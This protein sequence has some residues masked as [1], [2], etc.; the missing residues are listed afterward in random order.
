[1]MTFGTKPFGKQPLKGSGSH[2]LPDPRRSSWMFILL[3]T[4][5]GTM[6]T[7]MYVYIYT[8]VY[9]YISYIPLSVP[10]NSIVYRLPYIPFASSWIHSLSSLKNGPRTEIPCTVFMPTLDSEPNSWGLRW[11]SM[12]PKPWV[13]HGKSFAKKEKPSGI[14]KTNPKCHRH[15]ENI[16]DLLQLPIKILPSSWNCLCSPQ[17]SSDTPHRLLSPPRMFS[18]SSNF[19]PHRRPQLEDVLSHPG[20][21]Q[22]DVWRKSHALL[23]GLLLV[24]YH[25]FGG[26]DGSI[27]WH[28]NH[29]LKTSPMSCAEKNKSPIRAPVNQPC[30]HA[31]CLPNLDKR[32]ESYWLDPKAFKGYFTSFSLDGFPPN[33]GDKVDWHPSR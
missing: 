14:W 17:I 20:Q 21:V 18:W 6:V 31:T 22:G 26:K 15:S 8:Y 33:M 25:L 16:L 11:E 3:S 10:P 27:N 5:S 13:F 19:C 23:G 24:N 7:Y 1:M 30:L 12:L 32:W 28:V 29:I 2:C 4:W 9:I